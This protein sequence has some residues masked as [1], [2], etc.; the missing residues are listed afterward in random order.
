MT[1]V[2]AANFVSRLNKQAAATLK[3]IQREDRKEAQR[4]GFRSVDAMY[5]ANRKAAKK[6]TVESVCNG[7]KSLY[8]EAFEN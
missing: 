4:R 7:D 1:S 6:A 3:K 5:R 8:H 2:Q